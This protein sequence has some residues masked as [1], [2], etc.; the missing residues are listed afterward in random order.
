[1]RL[2]TIHAGSLHVTEGFAPPTKE[3]EM[4]LS[5][6]E[7]RDGIAAEH[8]AFAALLRELDGDAW[9]RPS[10]CEGWTVADVAAHVSGSM[11]EIMAGELEGQGTEPV[12]ARQVEQRR[13]RTNDELADELEGAAKG[14][15]DMLAAFDDDAWAAPS[16]G[17]FA[18]TLGD[19]VEALWF[20][21]Y[22][23]ADDIRAA[24][25]RPSVLGPGINASL[26]HVATILGQRG[27][28]PATLAFDGYDEFA[29]GGGGKRIDGDPLAFVLVA[30]GRADPSTLGLGPDVNI[31]A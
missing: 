29:V 11:A 5:L 25:G 12:T 18:G 2:P 1:M 15:A 28:G 10:R 22:L 3:A 20:D 19:A 30:T 16:P 23:H 27:W 9:T 26:S 6:H 8:Q 31:Y 7:V 21:T 24:V 14:A 13:G 17:G 4:T